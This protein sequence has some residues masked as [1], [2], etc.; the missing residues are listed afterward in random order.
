M[1]GSTTTYRTAAAAAHYRTTGLWTAETLVDR[2]RAHAKARPDALAIV[3]G[4]VD[5]EL[6]AAYGSSRNGSTTYGELWRDACRFAAFLRARGVR[7]GDGVSVQLPNR[8]AT[9]IVDLGVLAA[10][11]VLN[12]L[13]PSYRSHELRHI[14]AASRARVFV[15]PEE[16]RGFDHLAMTRALRIELPGLHTH[17]VVG[18]AGA[19]GSPGSSHADA[20]S[21]S[22]HA[23]RRD[24]EFSLDDA[25]DSTSPDES[26]LPALDAA[27]VSELIFTSGTESMPKAILH[28]EE[29]ANNSVRAAI[30]AMA[31]GPGD[32]VFMPSPIG[33]STG[34]NF[35]L[36]LALYAGLPIVL[37]DRWDP[38]RAAELVERERCTYTLAATTFLAD[39]VRVLG[40]KPRD[41]S[42]LR[43]FGCGGAPVPPELV[44]AADAVGIRVLRIYGSTEGLVL[45]WNRP[46]TAQSLRARTDGPPLPNVELEIRDEADQPVSAGVA[47][48][49]H[50]RGPS[51]CVG[52]FE[53][54]ERMARSFT[55]DGW[56][57]SGDL[58]VLD[59]AGHLTIVGRKKEIIIRGGLNIAPREIE[60]LLCEMPG[61]RAA[62]VIGLPDVR[63]GEIVCACLVVDPK[64]ARPALEDVTTFLRRRELAVYKLP[65]ALR[66]VSE[67]PT[68][69]SGK[70][71]KAALRE[72]IL[73]EGAARAE[74]AGRRDPEE[75]R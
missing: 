24:G 14:L 4:S 41:V 32:V 15:T 11:A 27:A 44:V 72:T 49:I 23:S 58:G 12:P 28:S 22:A 74:P 6:G 42:S 64:S 33:H 38:H 70:L 10:G 43:C 1:S 75:K 68:T 29:T 65:Q 7:P 8:R 57:R 71:R 45:T 54:P 20:R 63:L 13:L 48:E 25:L 30:E 73:A 26:T 21:T 66:V 59:E 60:D 36:R 62:A 52:F 56:L 67:I 51:L 31:L 9:A 18:S 40:E 47:G 2:L 46:G 55:P 3:D 19:S 17:V 16:E 53:D 34:L 69:A 37:Q 61:I 5:V 50:V 39:L 35:G